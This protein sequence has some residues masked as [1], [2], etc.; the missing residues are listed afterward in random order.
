MLSFQPGGLTASL[1]L[2]AR[3]LFCAY[4]TLAEQ[5]ELVEN[6]KCKTLKELLEKIMRFK[7][8]LPCPSHKNCVIVAHKNAST[9]CIKLNA[10]VHKCNAKKMPCH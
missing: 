6:K 4:I 7:F 2:H 1:G 8:C 9:D 10:C 5:S 3:F